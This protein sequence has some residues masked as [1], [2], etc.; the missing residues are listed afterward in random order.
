MIRGR[1]ISVQI[2]GRTIM[3]IDEIFIEP[4]KVTGLI[5]ES[6]SG[7]TTLL[8]CLG[9]LQPITTGSIEIDDRDFSNPSNKKR[10]SFWRDEAAFVFQDYGIIDEWTVAQNLAVAQNVPKREKDKMEKVLNSVS[11]HGRQGE[12][13]S[14]LS[15]GEKQR[16]G[17]ARALYREASYLFVDEP[18]A[19]LDEGNRANV[20][21]L[22]RAVADQGSHVVIATHDENMIL[23]CD[24][25]YRLETQQR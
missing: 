7:K 17:I 16:V 11:L 4:G 3:A 20:Q 19:S 6:G 18:T 13:A 12:K 24:V 14:R 9:L 25:T 1:D 21:R 15:G 22:L 8:N 10:L 2:K 5:G 23:A